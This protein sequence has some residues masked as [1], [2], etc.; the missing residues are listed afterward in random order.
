MNAIF[1]LIGFEIQIIS[2]ILI[3]IPIHE[4]EIQCPKYTKVQYI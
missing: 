2:T 3:L 4:T 1:W